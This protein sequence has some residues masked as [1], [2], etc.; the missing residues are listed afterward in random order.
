MESVNKAAFFQFVT[1]NIAELTDA[2]AD[3]YDCL[4]D[5]YLDRGHTDS[6]WLAYILAT[7][8]HEQIQV[9][10]PIDAETIIDSMVNGTIT[11]KALSRYLTLTKSDFRNSRKVY[12]ADKDNAEIV[13][14]LSY[15]YM[16]ALNRG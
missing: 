1:A 2:K 8:R 14:A 10:D 16:N 3:S 5:A 4:I 12:R 11:G 15:P 6:R 13:A 9:S 7:I